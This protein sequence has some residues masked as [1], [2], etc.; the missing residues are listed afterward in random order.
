[1]KA[2][3]FELRPHKALKLQVFI[4]KSVV[5]VFANDRQAVMRC[6]YPSRKDGLDVILF[7]KGGVRP[8]CE[9]CRRSK[10]T[11]LK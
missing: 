1:V 7:A 5:E 3:P 2:G 8:P 11:P 9:H 4:D 6:I 10:F